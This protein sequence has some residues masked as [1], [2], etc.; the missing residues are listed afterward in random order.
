MEEKILRI[1]RDNIISNN[2]T[3]RDIFKIESKASD[4]LVNPYYIK[5]KMKDVCGVDVPYRE[6]SWFINKSMKQMLKKLQLK[7]VLGQEMGMPGYVRSRY[8]TMMM[9]DLQNKDV[10]L[11]FFNFKE[12]ETMIRSVLT[13]AGYKSALAV[14]EEAYKDE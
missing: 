14:R 12:L 6:I 11:T 10:I 3:I 4:I 7:G 8:K 9:G 2:C 5:K 1:C 13:K